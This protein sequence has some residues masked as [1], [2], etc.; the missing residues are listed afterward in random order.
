MVQGNTNIQVGLV[1]TGTAVMSPLCGAP[2][3]YGIYT[4]IK[5]NRVW[6]DA[7]LAGTVSPVVEPTTTSATT[8]TIATTANPTT[9]GGTTVVATTANPSTTAATT[10]VALTTKPAHAALIAIPIGFLA[11][12]FLI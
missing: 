3:D 6:I 11:L 7:V 1:A 10:V 4:S 9:V 12:F 2:G 5:A 8:T